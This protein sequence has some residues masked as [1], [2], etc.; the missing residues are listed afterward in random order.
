MTTGPPTA[1]EAARRLWGRMR[2]QGTGRDGVAGAAE[3]LCTELSTDLRRWIGAEGYRALLDRS[4]ALT[5][6]AHPSLVGLSCLGGDKRAMDAAVRMHGAAH[7]QAGMLALITTLIDL[8]GHILGA[9]MA[10]RLVEQT[11]RRRP[12]GVASIAPTGDH[13]G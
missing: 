1:E 11:G 3:H 8:L 7:V 6:P 12:P 13:D 9:E 4:L 5:R 2:G 10:A